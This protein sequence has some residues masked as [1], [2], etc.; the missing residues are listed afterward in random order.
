MNTDKEVIS[1]LTDDQLK[2]HLITA[3]Y[4]GMKFKELVLEELLNRSKCNHYF[5]FKNGMTIKRNKD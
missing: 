4:K 2:N 5:Y 3:D 1:T